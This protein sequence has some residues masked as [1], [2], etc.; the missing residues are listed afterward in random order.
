MNT[1]PDPNFA[2]LTTITG[3]IYWDT[4]YFNPPTG[5]PSLEQAVQGIAPIEATLINGSLSI[6][7]AIWGLKG[8]K[9]HPRRALA[10]IA[11]GSVI[12]ATKTVETA[13]SSRGVSDNFCA[14]L[15]EIVLIDFRPT[16]P[17]QVA[18]LVVPNVGIGKF[19]AGVQAVPLGP[20]PML[21]GGDTAQCDFQVQ[22]L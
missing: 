18:I 19:E 3:H 11:D 12:S 21:A 15:Y 6:S 16:N 17:I 9:V 14:A 13:E 20:Q 8:Q 2:E 4:H 7:A 10:K 22:L 5:T 1:I